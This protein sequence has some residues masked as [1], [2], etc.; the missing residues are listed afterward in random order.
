MP[1]YKP[2]LRAV[3]FDDSSSYNRPNPK[4][5]LQILETTCIPA[6][7]NPFGPASGGFIKAFG[8]IVPV[9]VLETGH[10]F[11]RGI[12]NGHMFEL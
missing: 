1:S 5:D 9:R 8:L 7:G 3:D 2:N 11:Y 12:G 4:H 6:G 10:V